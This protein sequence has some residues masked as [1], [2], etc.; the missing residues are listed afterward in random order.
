MDPAL[1]RL[2]PLETG[3]WNDRV[4]AHPGYC[5]FHCREWAAVLHE[6]YG[7]VP[8]YFVQSSANGQLSALAAFMEASS[9]ITGRR[10]VSLPYSDFC[11][12]IPRGSG[13][14]QKLLDAVAGFG[15]ERGWKYVEFRTDT[16]DVANA[17]PSIVYK[18]HCLDLTGGC[19]QLKSRFKHTMRTAIRK[20]EEYGIT[21]E[22]SNSRAS[23][24]DYYAMHCQT[25]RRHGLPPQPFRFFRNIQRHILA[26]GRGK[27]VLARHDGR[28]VAGGVFLHFGRKTIFKYAASDKRALQMRPNNLVM[29]HAIRTYADEGYE[30]MCFGR[31]STNNAGLARFKRSFGTREIEVPYFRYDVSNRMFIESKERVF[32]WHNAIF[33]ALPVPALRVIGALAYGH[34]A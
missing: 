21:T 32:G 20:A 23:V 33:R 10:G 8:H 26:G 13:S 9:P 3:D 22:V 14:G 30:S 11:P 12:V 15:A 17:R 29:W 25:R 4:L 24:R 18:A 7:F 2:N 5:F 1:Q 28:V 6:T 27:L 19:S 34:S 31:T 16:L